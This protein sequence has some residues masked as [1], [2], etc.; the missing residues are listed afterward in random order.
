MNTNR[1]FVGESL[2]GPVKASRARRFSDVVNALYNSPTLPRS[3]N[4]FLALDEKRR[5]KAKQVRFLV[6]ACFKNSPSK[7]VYDQA[8]HCNLIILD[9]DPEKEMRDGKWVETG[10]YP[11]ARFVNDPQLLYTAL[12]GLNFAAYLTASSTPEKPRMRI[13]VDAERI[14]LCEYAAAV[15][16]IAE[17]LGLPSVT[18][19]ST[20]AVQPMFWPVRF[21]D[22][23]AD[24]QPIIAYR[25]NGRAF[26]VVDL[27]DSPSWNGSSGSNGAAHLNGSDPSAD[28]LENLRAPDPEISLDVVRDALSFLNPDCSRQ[29][30]IEI[31]AALKHQF[32]PREDAEAFELFD[33]WSKKGDKYDG[34]HETRSVWNSLSQTPKGRAP[35]TIRSLLSRAR[36]AGWVNPTAPADDAA[37]QFPR[38]NGLIGD[39]AR[40]IAR[41]AFV[42]ESMAMAACLGVLS[43]AIGASVCALDGGRKIPANE[44]FLI[45]AKS[46]TGK[47]LCIKIANEPLCAWQS[48]ARKKWRDEDAPRLRAQLKAHK[49]KQTKAEKPELQNIEELTACEIEAT[50]L[51]LELAQEPIVYVT[52]ATREAIIARL[53]TQKHEALAS[54][55]AEAR[56]A[57]AILQGRYN[58]NGSSDEDIFLAAY[59]GDALASDR[60]KDGLKIAQAPCLSILWAIQP[61]VWRSMARATNLFE[62]GLLPRFIFFDTKAEPEEYPL[63]MPTMSP[64]IRTAWA[65]C[66]NALLALRD[67][68]IREVTVS[69]EAREALRHYEN[70]CRSRARSG[71]DA[72]DVSAFAARWGENA[73]RLSLILHAGRHYSDPEKTPLSVETATD[74]IRLMEWFVREEMSLLA[75]VRSAALNQRLGKVCAWLEENG[76]QMTLGAL[77]DRYEVTA[78]EARVLARRF[79]KRLTIVEDT[80]PGPGRKSPVLALAPLPSD[81]SDKSE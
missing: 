54:I 43:A 15:T 6:A 33:A 49:A 59:S 34:E 30:W 69:P 38:I 63:E 32:S 29:E 70:S 28:E 16:A 58:S 51:E 10:R 35:I 57:V 13:I 9:I 47:S 11:T 26:D 61:D 1:Y 80:K 2:H 23:P 71:N 76:G 7:R 73:W 19:E 77:K 37:K 20:V 18:R 64:Q 42:P 72:A 41:C 21:S 24:Y 3:R 45:I 62:S 52:D 74:A 81:Q 4:A 25:T 14:P 66:I 68:E 53:A 5:N 39:V 48:E 44:Y 17:M 31:A 40:E 22:S 8:T 36:A 78:Q 46:G 75:E 60:K 55:N 27:L 79:P 12:D 56:G 50:R 65:A 67:G